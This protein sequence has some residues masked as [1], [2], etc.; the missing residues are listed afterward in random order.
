MEQALRSTCQPTRWPRSEIVGSQ[1]ELKGGEFFV[2][3]N[4]DGSM[5][6]SV[7]LSER[8]IVHCRRGPPSTSSDILTRLGGAY[9]REPIPPP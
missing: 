8:R 2:S 7:K 4:Q 1:A 3:Q 5:S 9:T 6:F